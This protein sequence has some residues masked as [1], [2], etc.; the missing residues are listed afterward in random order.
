VTTYRI[1]VMGG[2]G[3]QGKGLGYRFARHGHAVVIGSRAAEKAVATAEEIRARLAGTSG[4]GEVSGAANADAC[5]DAD[6]VV[7]AVP[8]DGHDDL[9]AALPLAGKTVVSCVNP[10]AFDKRGAHGLVI[11]A[12][13]GSAAERAQALAPDAT[14]VGA[15]HNVSAVAL[16]GDEDYLDDDVLCVGDSDDGKGVAMELAKAVTGREGISAGKLRLARQLEPLTAV[17]ISIN[18]KYKVHS[19]IRITGLEHTGD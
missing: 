4:A 12:G 14:V 7:V 10:L 16:W 11:D 1:A 2:T 3:P 9:V 17:L 6:V 15:F 13:E 19:G 5:A 18:R 8:W